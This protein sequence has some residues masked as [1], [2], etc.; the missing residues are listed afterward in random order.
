MH[1]LSVMNKIKLCPDLNFSTF[2]ELYYSM[3]GSISFYTAS[4]W[5]FKDAPV[6]NTIQAMRGFLGVHKFTAKRAVEG[7]MGWESCLVKQ[8]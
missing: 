8:S 7:D 5:D 3:V 2:T 1:Y 4:V 6:S